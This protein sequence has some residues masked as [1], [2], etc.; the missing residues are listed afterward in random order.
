[1]TTNVRASKRLPSAPVSSKSVG[2]VSPS[3]GGGPASAGADCTPTNRRTPGSLLL[4]PEYDNRD[5][6]AT[7]FT[8]T[9]THP[10]EEVFVEYVYIGRFGPA[11]TGGVTNGAFDNNG[12]AWTT[13]I[14]PAQGG[15]QG[16]IVFNA[17]R[18]C[19]LEGSSLLTT[20]S[21]TFVIPDGAQN[22]EFD[23]ILSPGFDLSDN[24][25]P[26]AFEA[27]LLDGANNSVVPTWFPGVTS[28]FNL[29]EDLTV[30]AGPG[31]TYQ[32]GHVLLDVSG[33]PTGTSVTLFF[34]F[35]GADLDWDGGVKISNVELNTG[36]PLDLQC[37]EFNRTELLTPNDTLTLL[38]NVHNP[39]MAQGY[40]YAFAKNAAGEAI[41]F[42]HL[43]G[44]VIRANGV[45]SVDYAVNAVGFASPLPL[46]AL[47]DLDTDDIRD[48]N[49]SEYDQAPAE[50]LIP[51][52]VGQGPDENSQ[53]ILIALSG[54]SQFETIVD[55]LVYN[56]NEQEFSSEY[57]FYCWDQV[58]LLSISALFGQDFL[59]NST[60]ENPL[61]SLGGME[62]GWLRLS[63]S[64]AS[65]SAY[66][67]P[68]P[69]VYAVYI[70]GFAN[71][72]AA[73]LPFVRCHRDAH[74][75]PR[76]LFGDNEE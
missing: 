70:E 40:A 4:F 15:P 50:I 67:I 9:N 44:Q 17:G 8:L 39:Q 2:V 16:S 25:I 31:V 22:L 47:T 28:F 60:A 62:T 56:D 63:G 1:M 46:A 29:Q 65:S 73:D 48:M 53:L 13:D 23:L 37:T 6:A 58:P 26:D 59:L 18:A 3:S 51:R 64:S 43:I 49:G 34:D 14:S 36:E 30:N 71:T 38:T 11:L 32:G 7:I 45:D 12:Q 24:F 5:G 20:L 54:G 33:V 75:L 27:Q 19:F 72:T 66:T 41:S 57:Q 69:A 68:D 42:N 61:E 35:I 52:F 55:L 10:T 74:L 21:Q 76:A